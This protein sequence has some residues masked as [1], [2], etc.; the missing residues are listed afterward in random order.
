MRRG[1]R[2]RAW[3][4]SVLA[5]IGLSLALLTLVWREW[6]EFLFGVD[7]DR[8][9][10]ALELLVAGA[11]LAASVLLARRAWRDWR[12]PHDGEP[13]RGNYRLR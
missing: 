13:P 5:V 8:H 1:S 3:L 4:E 9:F 11:F 10:G 12:I 2:A 7:P 6:I